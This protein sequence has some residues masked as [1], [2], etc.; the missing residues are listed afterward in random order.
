MIKA[1][2]IAGASAAGKTT[3]AH[4]LI[5]RGGFELVRSLTT[6]EVRPDS[7]G[8]EYIYTDREEFMRLVCSGAVLEH[9]EYSGNLYGTPRSEIE[10]IAATGK[11]PL[12]ILDL[13]GVRSLS[14][15]EGV[16]ACSVYIYGS[17]NVLE[18]RLYERYIGNTPSP[19]GLAKFVS[20]KEQNIT[21]YLG[22]EEYSP[23]LY[24]FVRGDGALSDS[25]DGV[26]R[27]YCGFLEGSPKDSDMIR[28]IASGLRDEALEKGGKGGL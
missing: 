27:A 14:V 10:R 4:K 19:D 13:D 6:R 11:T 3:V 24:A 22:M 23:Y 7:F 26:A 16:D 21:D 2:I 9:T 12:L 25:V 5:E 1:L 20:R 28:R 17:L 18:T 15:A 8:A